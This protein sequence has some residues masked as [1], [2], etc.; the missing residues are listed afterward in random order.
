[1]TRKL[2]TASFP[3]WLVAMMDEKKDRFESRSQFLQK[4]VYSHIQ[5][6]DVDVSKTSEL[7]SPAKVHPT[8]EA[9]Q[10]ETSP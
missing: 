4:A 1:M 10:K 9:S 7:G 3:D 5:N 8:S 2:I 6:M